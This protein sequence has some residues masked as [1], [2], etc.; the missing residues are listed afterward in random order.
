MATHS[1]RPGRYFAGSVVLLGAWTVVAFLA[2]A[3][4]GFPPS[5]PLA[6]DQPA[7]TEPLAGEPTIERVRRDCF[8]ASS[9]D[10]RVKI[11]RGTVDGRRLYAC[12]E[13]ADDGAVLQAAVV[14]ADGHEVRDIAT[15]KRAGAWRWVGVATSDSEI[16]GSILVGAVV[17]FLARAIF[18]GAR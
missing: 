5:G 9:A 17:L 10:D 6:L 1:R 8:P 7:L 16:Y 3:A 14:D 4:D 13:L 12:Y 11:V 18:I 2:L 15:I